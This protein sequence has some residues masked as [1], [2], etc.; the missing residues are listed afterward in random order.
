MRNVWRKIAEELAKEIAKVDEP[1]V[2]IMCIGNEMRGDDGFG[3]LIARRLRVVEKLKIVKVL[4]CGTVPEN[5]TGVIRRLKPSH[6]VIVDAVDFGG[7]PGDVIVSFDPK[8]DEFTVSSHKPSLTMLAKYIKE[9]IG[10][11]VI[12]LGVQP[13]AIDVGLE[14]SSE[15]LTSATT[16]V[17]AFRSALKKIKNLKKLSPSERG[18]K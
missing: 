6:V 15:V 12:L 5:Y 4:N 17:K 10:S 13:K 16:V 18:V 7:A 11:K 9:T 8:F 3:P 14:M 1:F 2:V